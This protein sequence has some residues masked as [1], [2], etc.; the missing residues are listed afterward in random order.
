M[1]AQLEASV[2]RSFPA[3][4]I[5]SMRANTDVA[6]RSRSG[7]L[8][9]ICVPRH[10]LVCVLCARAMTNVWRRASKRSRPRFLDTN[11]RRAETR[12]ARP[13][14]VQRSEADDAEQ[15]MP[16]AT[17]DRTP[18]S[19]RATATMLPSHHQ[20][21]R[22]WRQEP[23]TIGRSPHGANRHKAKRTVMKLPPREWG[24][25]SSYASKF[26]RRRNRQYV[27]WR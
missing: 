15:W 24:Q 2:R 11:W 22:R 6:C 5:V 20:Q 14:G 1:G 9:R 18:Q 19:S 10:S 13:P 16:G 25:S 8:F 4:V 27:A 7:V 23:Q 3:Q 21:Q 17:D 12:A 26:T